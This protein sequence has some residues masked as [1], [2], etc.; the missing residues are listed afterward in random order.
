MRVL[1]GIAVCAAGITGCKAGTTEGPTA[2]ATKEPVPQAQ[3]SQPAPYFSV[4]EGDYAA[5]HP[6]Y[7][8]D[9]ETDED[10]LAGELADVLTIEETPDGALKVRLKPVAYNGDE[11]YF[12]ETMTASGPHQWRWQGGDMFPN[13]EVILVQ[14]ATAIVITSNWDCKDEFCG[15]RATL[16]GSFPMSAHEPA[17]THEEWWEMYVR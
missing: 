5:G 1:L 14:T 6:V 12:S 13:C 9:A 15:H 8:Y 11:C 4:L 17:G 7:Y 3:P 16:E 10:V 2:S